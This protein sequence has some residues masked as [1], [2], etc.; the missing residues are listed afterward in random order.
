LRR[1]GPEKSRP[2]GGVQL[3]FFGDLYQLPPVV[4]GADREIFQRHY[5]SPYFFFGARDGKIQA[6]INRAGKDL[7][8]K[9]RSFYPA[10]STRFAITRVTAPELAW[11]NCRLD[12]DFEPEAK[13]LYITLTATNAQAD[14][15]NAAELSKLKTAEKNIYRRNYRRF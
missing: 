6:G 11:L 7:P 4:A 2:F 8:A 9:R 1:H 14:E 13:E 12:P 5:E 3:A 15:V 10:C